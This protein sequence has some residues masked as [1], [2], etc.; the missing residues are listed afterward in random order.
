MYFW[1]TN[2]QVQNIFIT[3]RI[4]TTMYKINSSTSYSCIPP[5]ESLFPIALKRKSPSIFDGVDKICPDKH[6]AHS[7][8]APVFSSVRHKLFT[9][10]ASFRWQRRYI[11]SASHFPKFSFTPSTPI[12]TPSLPPNL[13]FHGLSH[14]TFHSILARLLTDK[15]MACI[16]TSRYVRYL[17]CEF[18][19]EFLGV[20]SR[21]EEVVQGFPWIPS[22]RP[23]LQVS[24]T[25]TIRRA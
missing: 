24:P 5:E 2:F 17:L 1:R 3:L 18:G 14:Y 16:L 15:V 12:H 20:G 6:S 19:R 11:G 25:P 22:F 10:V 8:G 9:Q 7:L 21:S 13:P 4:L 23:Q